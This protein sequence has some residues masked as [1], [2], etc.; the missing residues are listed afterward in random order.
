MTAKSHDEIVLYF[1]NEYPEAVVVGGVRLA[2]KKE[3]R[4]SRTYAS[5]DG[6]TL[7]QVSRFMDGTADIALGEIESS[8]SSWSREDRI[9]FCHAASWLGDHPDLQP[10]LRHIMAHGEPLDWST[11]SVAIASNLPREEACEFLGSALM[12]STAGSGSNFAQGLAIT[13]QSGASDVLRRRLDVLHVHPEFVTDDKNVNWIA[14]EAT[15]CIAALLQ[16]G[17]PPAELEETARRLAQHAC[18]GNRQSAALHLRA[19][20]PGF[21]V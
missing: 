1:G 15:T 13:K 17:V 4:W 8:W 21:F 12:K 18:A 2:L 14:L 11:L 3:R 7:T 16:L 19:Y 5:D 20:Y 9:D 6:K 10:I